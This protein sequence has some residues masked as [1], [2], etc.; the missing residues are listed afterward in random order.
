MLFEIGKT[1]H[2]KTPTKKNSTKE[3]SL[4]KPLVK[5]LHLQQ[6]VHRKPKKL[7]ELIVFG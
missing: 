5:K 3:I 7:Q 1:L 4:K 6:Q 2:G